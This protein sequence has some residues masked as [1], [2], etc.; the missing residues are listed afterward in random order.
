MIMMMMNFQPCIG[1]IHIGK[2][3]PST[4]VTSK[5]YH[6]VRDRPMLYIVGDSI[7]QFS[8]LPNGFQ[9]LFLGWYINM[10][11]IINRGFSGWNTDLLVNIMENDFEQTFLQPTQSWNQPV[12]VIFTMGA[13]DACF[14]DSPTQQHVPVERY[15][16]NI[17]EMIS[18]MK[19]KMVSSRI[20][21]ILTTPPPMNATQW[22]Q[23]SGPQGGFRDN[24]HTAMY[25]QAVREI[26]TSGNNNDQR[27]NVYL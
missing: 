26:V 14:A 4:I 21:I 17:K 7:T 18:I 10:V 25:A 2:V 23:T 19:K 5:D 6:F 12:L 16:E 22:N 13:N 3:K 20:D 8:S 15:T 27:G 24:K 11:D 1:A 9:H